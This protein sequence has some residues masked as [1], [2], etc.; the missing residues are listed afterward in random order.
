MHSLVDF[1]MCHDQGSATLMYQDD[2]L[3]DSGVGHGLEDQKLT[4]REKF[5]DMAIQPLLFR[6]QTTGSLLSSEMQKR[7]ELC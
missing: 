1:C 2:V 6:S 4:E 3:N 5:T 7:K